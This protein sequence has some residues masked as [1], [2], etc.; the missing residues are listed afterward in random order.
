MA[1]DKNRSIEINIDCP[2]DEEIKE[3]YKELLKRFNMIENQ[4]KILIFNISI[5]NKI[6]PY[7]RQICQLLRISAKNIESILDEKDKKKALGL[8]NI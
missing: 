4:I 1:K 7:V 6:R 2:N 5:N 3:K 8:K